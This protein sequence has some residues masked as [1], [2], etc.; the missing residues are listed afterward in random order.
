MA[1][2]Q[3]LDV[4][5]KLNQ[6]VIYSEEDTPPEVRPSAIGFGG[7]SS[8]IH[9]DTSICAEFTTEPVLIDL[10][11]LD[12]LEKIDKVEYHVALLCLNDGRFKLVDAIENG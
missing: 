6:E 3:V 10:E 11:T 8:F 4:P 1:G 5:K 7:H 9:P 12:A 2:A